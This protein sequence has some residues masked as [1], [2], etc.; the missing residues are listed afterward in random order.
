VAG[1]VIKTKYVL[2]RAADNDAF[3][4]AYLDLSDTVLQ[5]VSFKSLCDAERDSLLTA[6]KA[7]GRLVSDKDV[8]MA[9]MN[10]RE[11][12]IDYAAGG[13]AIE[14]VLAQK[15]R[16]GTRLFMIAVAGASINPNAA[17]VARFFDSFKVDPEPPGEPLLAD[18]NAR[19]KPA[20]EPPPRNRAP[21]GLPAD[22]VVTVHVSGVSSDNVGKVIR[23]RLQRLLGPGR[24]SMRSFTSRGVMTVTLYPVGDAEAFAKKIEFG[25]V[26]RVSGRDIFVQANKVDVPGPGTDAIAQALFDLKEGDSIARKKAVETLG[27]QTPNER[28]A[29]IVNVLEPLLKS[30]DPFVRRAAVPVLA[31]WGGKDSVPA[32]VQTLHNDD[33]FTRQAALE[34]LANLKDARAVEP[35]AELLPQGIDRANAGKALQAMGS[36]AEKAVAVYL[37]HGDFGTRLEACHI[38]KVIGTKESVAALQKAT[39]NQQDAIVASAAQE[40]LLA[41]GQRR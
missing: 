26:T 19:P 28:R 1:P 4:V 6:G 20:D 29:E 16:G 12:Q 11:F 15:K 18:N 34:S 8:T 27:R 37:T 13:M 23:N 31:L 3:V 32:L 14:R 10:G 33:V 2:N 40:A 5:V 39:L 38:L 9:G 36:M 30:P 21:S 17:S 22:Q 35:M 25:K 24:T 41:I 7:Q